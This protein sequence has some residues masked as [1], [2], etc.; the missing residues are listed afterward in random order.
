MLNHCLSDLEDEEPCQS[1]EDYH[2]DGV[3]L[4]DACADE[5]EDEEDDARNEMEQIV[6]WR[7]EVFLRNEKHCRSGYE[8][9]YGR[10]ERT[11]DVID[12]L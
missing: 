10:T 11:E 9:D 6:G 5:G 8:S 1:A 3:K 7:T 2:K 12:K 4:V